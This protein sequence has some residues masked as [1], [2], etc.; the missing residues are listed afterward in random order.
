MLTHKSFER[1]KV[2]FPFLQN[3]D[4]E[5]DF[6]FVI[7]SMSCLQYGSVVGTR[8]SIYLGFK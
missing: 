1:N 4:T 3:I 6:D 2:D 5:F 7:F 8:G